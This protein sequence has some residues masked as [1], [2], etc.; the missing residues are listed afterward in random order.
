[1]SRS[2]PVVMLGACLFTSALAGCGDQGSD[3]TAT[4]ESSTPEATAFAEPVSTGTQPPAVTYD[5]TLIPTSATAT[6]DTD[7]DGG[8]T[9][10]ALS[11]SG[12]VPDRDYGAHVHTQQ[13]GA[14]PDDSGPHY[15]NQKDPVTPSDPDYANAENEIWLDFTTDA[16]GAATATATVDWEFRPGEANSLVIH[17]MHTMS[18]AGKAGTAGDRLAC[19]SAEF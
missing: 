6:V 7:S 8:T 13:C 10:V 19:I 12:L 11:V 3:E 18:E 1:M 17:Q 9:E 14:K 16:Q 2:F 4:Q 15:Q 5:T